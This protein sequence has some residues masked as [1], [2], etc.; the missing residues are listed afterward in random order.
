MTALYNEIDPDAAHVLRQLI[1]DGVIAPGV[2]DTRSIKDLT[3]DDL[4]GFTQVHFFAGGGLWSVAARMAGWPDDRPL[5]TGSCPCQ[6]HSAAASERKRGFEDDRDLWPCWM[7]LVAECRPDVVAGEQVDDSV[8]WIDRMLADMEAA[9]Y[10]VGTMDLPSCAVDAPV[11]GM[12]TFFVAEAGGA[13][14]GEPGG[15]VAVATPPQF[16]GAQRPSGS[17]RFSDHVTTG[18]LGRRRRFEPGVR[19]LADDVPGRVALLRLAG[20]AINPRLAAQVLAAYL[21]TERLRLMGAFA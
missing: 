8:A 5:W 16:D 3:P 17:A 4:A 2:V 14:C 12:R 15:P 19:L 21:G 13:G 20:N 1:A 10:A 6:P 11:V 9:G 18:E 7:G